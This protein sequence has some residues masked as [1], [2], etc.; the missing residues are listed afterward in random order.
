MSD[1]ALWLVIVY[2]VALKLF[3]AGISAL[4][5]AWLAGWSI[6]GLVWLLEGKDS[7]RVGK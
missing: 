5:I 2:E 7:G 3:L 6:I 4:L 1:V